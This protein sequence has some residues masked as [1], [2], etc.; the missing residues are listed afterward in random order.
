MKSLK[1]GMFSLILVGAFTLLIF[2][3]TFHSAA[4]G[5]KTIK[6]TFASSSGAASNMWGLIHIRAFKKWSRKPRTDV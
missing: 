1:W 6:W 4:A 5:E 2:S 3:G